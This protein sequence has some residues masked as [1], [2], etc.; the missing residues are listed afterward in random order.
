VNGHRLTVMN[1]GKGTVSVVVG[2]CHNVNVM[3]MASKTGCEALGE[4]SRT[5]DVWREC[6][7]AN[8]N[9]QWL[10]SHRF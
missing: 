5:I 2:R 4:S 7:T 1:L 9:G 6:V 8:H 3:T 10:I